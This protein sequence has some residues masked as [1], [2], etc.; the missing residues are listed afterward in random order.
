[1]PQD[2]LLQVGLEPVLF[3]VSYVFSVSKHLLLG[4]LG[5][6]AYYDL[7]MTACQL[8]YWFYNAEQ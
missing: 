8:N 6:G 2:G 1:M 7:L 3:Q 4:Y 5:K